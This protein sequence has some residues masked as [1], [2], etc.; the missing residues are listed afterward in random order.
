MGIFYTISIV[1]LLIVY[2]L[3]KKTDKKLDIIGQ[4]GFG[5]VLLFCY[6]IFICYLMTFFVIPITLLFLSVINIIL[7]LL[8][9]IWIYKKKE[10]QKYKLEKVDFLYITLLGIITLIVSYL[11]FGF[12]FQIKY[13][14]GDPSVH[15]L[16]SEMF[17][18]GT[19][20]LANSQKDEVY[21]SF[22]SRKPASYVNS[23]LIMKCFE[24]II[25]SFDYYKIFIS[26]GIFILFLTSWIMYSLLANFTKTKKT[27]LLAFLV[28]VLYTMGYPLN[29][30]VFGFEYLSMGILVLQ[31]ILQ[32]VNQYEK[33]EYKYTLNIVI[34]F[35]LNFGL[36]TS[37]YMF[38][39][40]TYSALWIYFCINEYKSKK[41]LLT[42]QL[43]GILCITLIM[44]FILGYIYHLAP[45]I[46]GIFIR[47][48]LSKDKIM[49]LS[50]YILNEGL[51]QR[52]YIYINFF[53]N[54]IL[55]LPFSI[56]AII[57]GWKE[58]KL[59][60]I[61]TLFNISFIIIL[62]M[63]FLCGKVSTY[64]ISKNYFALWLFLYYLN[65]KGFL[66]IYEKRK[67]IPFICISA[68]LVLI[69]LN[70]LFIKVKLTH[71]DINVNE[72]MKAIVDIYGAN[73]TILMDK[74]ID[75]NKGELDILRY[76]KDNINEDKKIEFAG[77]PEQGYWAYSILRRLNDDDKRTGEA[78]LTFKMIYVGERANKVDYVVYFNRGYFYKYWKD[79]LWENAEVIYENADGG[80][81]Q[82]MGR[83]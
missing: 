42:K 67:N 18:E 9:S 49:E 2:L 46:Y 28:S 66:L 4:I 25:D 7:S 62:M 5:I 75:L 40:Y 73:K 39:P 31:S 38:V 45:E 80:I 65:F 33:E 35:L 10:T 83:N 60:S 22:V 72:N 74:P 30:F 55:L 56:I 8:I 29:S 79:K 32:A 24:G 14:T 64:Y 69:V 1:I 52:G 36:F 41:K 63:G 54:I 37:Y 34:F 21:G 53:S 47:Q 19:S 78:K 68:Y 82:Y 20:L 77:E 71:N 76:V 17:A 15:Y 81:L 43:I 26:F 16:T 70:L 51:S 23:G 59:V 57:K 58:N 44:P 3:L 61:M 6:N 12:P 13:E 50:T 11:N 48:S 27:R